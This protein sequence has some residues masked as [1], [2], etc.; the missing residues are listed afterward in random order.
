M[1]NIIGIINN[2]EYKKYM[3]DGYNYI[4]AIEYNKHFGTI[5]DYIN[6]GLVLGAYKLSASKLKASN[7]LEIQNQG[8]I[9]NETLDYTSLTP[10]RTG[11]SFYTGWMQ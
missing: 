2:I 5:Y 11:F 10:F 3:Q 6:V 8:G 4:N 9:Q 1:H 7:L